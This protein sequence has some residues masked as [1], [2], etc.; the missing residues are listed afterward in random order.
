[1][2][3]D[4]NKHIGCKYVF[5]KKI[6]LNDIVD[7]YNTRLVAKGYF[8]VEEIFFGEMFSPFSMLTSIRILLSTTTNFDLEIEHMD[9]KTT[10][11][12][13]DLKEEIYMIQP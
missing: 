12:H 8:Q 5:K 1:L 4:G 2:F 6:G 13:G 10:F 11:L 3:H 9:V 7:K